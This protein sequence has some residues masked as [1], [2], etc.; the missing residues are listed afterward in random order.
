[1]S[2]IVNTAQIEASPP[3]V[4]KVL[5][6]DFGGI[7]RWAKGVPNC[8]LDGAGPVGVGTTRVIEVPR[9]FTLRE[10]IV[11]FEAGAH[12]AYE[13]HGLPSLIQDLRSDWYLVPKDGGTEVRFVS[14]S[15][16]GWGPVGKVVLGAL[17]GQL[18]RGLRG[19]VRALKRH[20]E[21]ARDSR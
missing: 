21:R 15:R 9:L 2:E 8:R 7:Q 13:V 17:R 10:T 19:M 14:S 3:E 1:M 6:E 12:L 18:D 11:V 4:W 16:P 20:V 5:A